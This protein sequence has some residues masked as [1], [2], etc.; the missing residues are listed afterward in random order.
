MLN[1]SFDAGCDGLMLAA[2]LAMGKTTL[3]STSIL[4]E[5]GETHTALKLH[6]TH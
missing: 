4:N 3:E 6:L 1:W 5:K 2:E